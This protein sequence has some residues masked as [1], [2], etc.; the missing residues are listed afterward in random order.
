LEI[1][2]ISLQDELLTGPRQMMCNRV[3]QNVKV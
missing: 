1:D 3:I 2:T